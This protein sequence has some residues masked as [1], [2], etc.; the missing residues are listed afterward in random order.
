MSRT[1]TISRQTRETQIQLSINLDGQGQANIDTP[2]GFLNHMLDLFAKHSLI[3]LTVQAKGDTEIDD[4][5]TTEDVGIC[6][7]LALAQAVGDKKGM[8]RYGHST[9]PMD[10]TLITSAVDLGGRVA[11]V[12]KVTF[13]SPK[14]GSFDTELVREFWNGVTNH[15]RMNFHAIAHHG[16]NS[17]HLAEGVFKASARAIRQAVAI[18]PRQGDAVASTKGTI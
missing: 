1:A 7:G 6:L 4:H 16:E 13:P 17:H 5:H 10:E 11:F 14:I 8:V 12:W 18:D 2:V 3:D 15:A 9:L